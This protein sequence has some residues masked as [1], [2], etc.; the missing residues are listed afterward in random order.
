M[1]KS[2][3]VSHKIYPNEDLSE[4]QIYVTI[5]TFDKNAK[6]YAEKWE[7]D[8][9]MIKEITKYNIDPFLKYVGKGSTCL[10]AGCQSGRDCLILTKAGLSCLGV[11]ASYG[12]LVEAIER[13]PKGIFMYSDLRNLPFMPD[14]FDSV[15]ADALTRIPRRDVKA[16]IKDLKIFL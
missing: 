8:P 5:Q 14:S 12:L 9:K 10:I 11:S 3:S 13:V 1:K 16:V 6:E 4:T 2:T 7:W 15:Y